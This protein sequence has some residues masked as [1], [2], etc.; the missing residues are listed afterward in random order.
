MSDPTT[1]DRQ[2]LLDLFAALG[3]DLTDVRDV[4]MDVS[5]IVLTR[6]YR[7]EAG[8]RVLDGN[9]ENPQPVTERI[10]IAIG[11]EGDEQ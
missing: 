10:E 7:N 1:V 3:I 4:A 6:Y 5:R 2:K 9:Y 8:N 11:H